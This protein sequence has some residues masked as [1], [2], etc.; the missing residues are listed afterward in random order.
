MARKLKTI[1][2][3]INEWAAPALTATVEPVTVS[4]DRRM[5][6]HPGGGRMHRWPGK[7][8]KGTLL[9]VKDAAGEIVLSHNSAHGF[10]TN[11]E[12]EEW[13]ARWILAQQPKKR[14]G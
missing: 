1:A 13:L 7:G 5:P 9:T 10:R 3:W 11:A 4:T 6:S 8:R 12:V 2:K 14:S